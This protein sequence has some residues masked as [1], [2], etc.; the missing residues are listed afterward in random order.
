MEALPIPLPPL[1]E[2][3]RIV[4]VVDELMALL[5]ALEAKQTKTRETQGR[6][7]SAALVA[8]MVAG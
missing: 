8:E 2:Q 3:K 4:A 1:P 7:R 6:L 5:D